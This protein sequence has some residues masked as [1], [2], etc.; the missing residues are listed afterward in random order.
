MLGSKE[1][2]AKRI[3]RETSQ[4]LAMFKQIIYLQ[5]KSNLIWSSER[6]KIWN[7]NPDNPTIKALCHQISRLVNNLKKWLDYLSSC[8]LTTGIDKLW[9]TIRLL[10]NPRK[11]DVRVTTKLANTTINNR[12]YVMLVCILPEFIEHPERKETGWNGKLF[13][14]FTIF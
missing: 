8:N 9:S 2:K 10:S 5:Y 1:H 13:A 12:R 11:M 3:F 6:D 4:L 14:N 7:S